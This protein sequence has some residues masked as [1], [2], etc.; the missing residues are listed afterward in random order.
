VWR[1][2]VEVHV[3]HT[4][5]R[6]FQRVERLRWPCRCETGIAVAD[7]ARR[8]DRVHFSATRLKITPRRRKSEDYTPGIEV[9]E[10]EKRKGKVVEVT[11]QKDRRTGRLKPYAFR[12]T[13]RPFEETDYPDPTAEGG[14][15]TL[16][17]TEFAF[18]EV[19]AAVIEISAYPTKKAAEVA[20]I[21]KAAEIAKAEGA[22]FS[23][24]VS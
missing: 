21:A 20:A 16:R 9:M 6:P 17:T 23:G 8:L 15:V 14:K 19:P 2:A 13:C 24:K 18:G 5:F 1:N 12:I 3:S 4:S 22:E 7:E 11:E 10:M